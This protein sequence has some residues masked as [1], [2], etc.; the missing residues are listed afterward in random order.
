MADGIILFGSHCD[1]C[2]LP[3]P[4]VSSLVQAGCA[5][6]LPHV[7]LPHLRSSNM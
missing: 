3:V 1:A 5:L 2:V 7:P 6:L 4:C